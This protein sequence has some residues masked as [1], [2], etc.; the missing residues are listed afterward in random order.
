[1]RSGA[2]AGAIADADADA[3]VDVMLMPM[4]LSML[5]LISMLMS[6]YVDA[7]LSRT[8]ANQVVLVFIRHVNPRQFYLYISPFSAAVH[9]GE[10]GVIHTRPRP[11]RYTA[12]MPASHSKTSYRPRAHSQRTTCTLLRRAL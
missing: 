11:S 12:I 9:P 8:T 2:A 4:L 10:E 6:I 3:V 5:M 1:M 7:I